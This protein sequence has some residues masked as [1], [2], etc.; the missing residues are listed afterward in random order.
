M[1]IALKGRREDRCGAKAIWKDSEPFVENSRG[2][3]IHRPRDI[4]TYN[5][6]GYKPHL[7]INYYCGGTSTGNDNFTFLAEVPEDRLLCQA[8]ENRALM[9]G[10]KS[11]DEIVGRH[12]HKGK[13][14][15]VKTCCNE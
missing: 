12:V 2:I 3:L 11:A 1:K 15:Q 7:G 10:Q 4:R 13:L 8:C 5:L 6:K 14:K 9:C